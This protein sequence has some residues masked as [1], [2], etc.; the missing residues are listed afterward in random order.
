MSATSSD[1]STV[2]DPDVEEGIKYWESQPASYD[3]VLGGFGNGS[4]PR[5]DALGTRQFLMYLLPELCTVPSAVRPLDVPAPAPASARRT[6]VLDVGAGV[7][8]VTSDVLLHL[9]ADVVLVEPVERFIAEAVRRGRASERAGPA[10]PGTG[11]SIAE[12]ANPEA[13]PWKGIGDGRKSV[14]FVQATLQDF[15]PARPSAGVAEGKAKILGRVGYVPAEDDL[16]TGFDVVVCQW[17]LG[18]MSDP[19]LVAFFRRSKAALRDP[20]RGFIIVKENLCSE[21]GEP[22]V[23]FDESDSSLTRSDLA[24]KQAFAE[25]G[26]RVVHE[27]IQRGFPEGLYPVKMY[28]LQ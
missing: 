14:T 18:A 27:Q 26:L 8:R 23:V 7:G 10:A 17:C 15:D 9:F 2:P 13:A 11:A 19:D 3:G 22:R 25:A 12:D 5:V 1:P 4:L 6:R 21:K 24:W 28:A 16:D 20:A